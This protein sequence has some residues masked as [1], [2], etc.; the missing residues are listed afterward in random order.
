MVGKHNDYSTRKIN[1]I[2]LVSYPF[3]QVL[4]L[5][6]L[7]FCQRPLIVE[8]LVGFLAQVVNGIHQQSQI[9]LQE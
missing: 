9:L 8:K 3:L 7:L 2:L 5:R 6:L 4:L 1:E